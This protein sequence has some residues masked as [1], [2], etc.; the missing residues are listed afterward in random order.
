MHYSLLYYC[1]FYCFFSVFVQH[2]LLVLQ[3]TNQN[4][5]HMTQSL[6]C[7]SILFLYTVEFLFKS[8]EMMEKY[9]H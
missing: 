4:M 3:Q 9:M 5:I 2:V 1:M 7:F 8:N 6:F